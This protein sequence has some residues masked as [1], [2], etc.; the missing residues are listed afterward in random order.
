MRR[1]GFTLIELL[2]VI[3]II[4]ILIGLLLPAVQKVRDAA[5][6]TQCQ[7]NLKQLGLAHHNYHDANGHLMPMLSPTG[8]C[9]GTWAVLILP[10]I[11]QDN[12]YWLYQNWGGTDA[13]ASHYPAPTPAGQTPPRYSA[14]PNVS[15][16]TGR[17]FKTFTCPGDQENAPIS[18]GGVGITSNN[19]AVNGGSGGTFLTRPAIAPSTFVPEPGLFD[20][21]TAGRT[22]RKIRLTSV[23]DG[24]TNTVLMGEVRQGQGSD[25]RGFIWY[26][27]SAAMSTYS[28]PNTSNP[29]QVYRTLY[30]NNQ[31]L[32]GL[33]CTGTGGAVYYSRSRHSGG[34]NVGMGDGSVRFVSS[35][36]NPTT[37]LYMGPGNDG[38]VIN[39]DG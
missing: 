8:C 17:R 3:A 13:V 20:G 35:T 24:L 9:W 39:I 7:N 4:A 30:C 33:P 14:Q 22:S 23:S 34:V 28:P 29:D 5:A 32:T 38:R 21:S 25:L 36:I 6:R 18:S 37:W 12:A 10:F 11:E 1:N 2:V 16:V 15:N 19:Y 31:P 27:D 26:G